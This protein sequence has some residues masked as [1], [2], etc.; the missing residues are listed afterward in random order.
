MKRRY[1]LLA[2]LAMGTLGSVQAQRKRVS[3]YAPKLEQLYT[4]ADDAQ[5]PAVG[6]KP[7]IG[8]SLGYSDKKN[9]V[10]NT[11][12]NSILK[13]GGVPYLIPVTDDVEVLRQI[14]A[15]LDGIVFTGGEDFAPAY[16]GKE[17]H[18]KLGEVNVTRDTYDLT[19]LKLATDRNIPTLG[20]CR[21]LQLINV[22][23]GGTL[24]QDLPA[25]KPSD[26]NHRQEEEG[27]VPT[28][29]VSV[30]EGSVMHNIFGKQEIQVNTFHHQAIDKLA[31]GLKIVGWSND[32][33]PE[34]IEAYPH[35]QILG[36][37]FHPEIFTAAGDALM[38]KLFKFL[39]NKA[40]TFK[41]AKDIHTRILSVDTHTD[42]PLW[43]TR[44]NFSVGMRK[45][46]QVSIQKME[47][48]KL[49]AQ[50]LAAFLAQKELDEVS[51]QKAV[52]K[53]HKM[54]EGIYADVAKYKDECGIALTEEDA[55]RLKA[56]GKK[57][58]FIGIENGYAIG[59]DIKNVKKYKDMGVQ[60]MTLSHSYDND[61]CN[62]SSNTADASKGLTAFGRKVVKEMN[63]VGMMID[64]SHVSEGTF[65]DVI[66]LSKDPIFASHS[67][68]RALCDHD[69]NLTDE[70]LRA[71]AKNGGVI[72]I[73]IYGGYLNKDAKTASV[74]DVV[75]HIDHAVKV[76]GI[77]HVGIGS[78]FD[79][80]GGVL[81]CAG[82]NDMIN[83]TVKLIEKGYSEEDLR[84]I[85]GGNFFRVMNQVINK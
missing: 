21:G 39:V 25:E 32:S 31:P 6:E 36:T 2:L 73:C 44:G 28:H 41:M 66:K 13:N 43:F 57:A 72:Q 20:I 77:D 26:I 4:Q 75:R 83:I 53:C 67:S 11:Y 33:V 19:L 1:L 27:T 37:Q 76:A 59:K 61:I 38:G 8:I 34:L 84:K 68:V 9:S 5:R 35:R 23:M 64:V 15:Q 63:K 29:S 49:D 16:Y 7:L 81:G 10:N 14:V 79:G 48:G 3:P 71:L 51:S 46:N 18:E 22:G 80:G 40:D 70:Q 52:E 42:T 50:F 69:R 62:S 30:V 82:D 78:D 45:S 12:I 56:E 24:Y 47:E 58:F 65:W 55:R 17:E 85:W 74:D 60:Y 54:I